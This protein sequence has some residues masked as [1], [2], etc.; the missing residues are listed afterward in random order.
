MSSTK[1]KRGQELL[2]RAG[3][4]KG[5]RYLDITYQQHKAVITG[6]LIGMAGGAYI[7]YVRK[8]NMLVTSLLGAVAGMIIAGVF[9]PK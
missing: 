4:I 9:L 3:A 1:D 6:G 8:T 5:D 7:G 2:D